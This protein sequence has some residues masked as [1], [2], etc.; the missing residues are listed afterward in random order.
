[1]TAINA[2]FCCSSLFRLFANSRINID[3]L[4]HAPVAQRIRASGFEPEGREFES[5][6]ARHFHWVQPG[7]NKGTEIR[8][9]E[10]V[11]KLI[12]EAK[13]AECSGKAARFA[14]IL[15]PVFIPF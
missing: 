9:Q 7:G 5:L 13:T 8:G 6:R 2:K 14:T 10:R 3:N 4:P 11:K 1:V 15:S 12:F